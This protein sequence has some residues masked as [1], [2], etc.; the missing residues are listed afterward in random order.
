MKS[1]V[2]VFEITQPIGMFA[3]L[4][5]CALLAKACEEK[6]I[7]P[8]IVASSPLYLS[9]ARG[10]DWF[11]YFFGHKRIELTEHDIAALRKEGRILVIRD[12]NQINEFAR[13]LA[14]HEISNEFSKFSEAARLF[15]KYF[16]VNSHVL[17]SVAEF[18]E[19]NF[20]RCGQLGMHYRGTDHFHEYKF[21]DQQL[22]VD[23][24][25][26]HFPEYESIFIATDE[27]RFL[28][29]VRSHMPGKRIVT[30][31]P[32]PPKPHTID[33]GDNYRKGS[34][35][36]ADCL[37]LSRCH[38]LVKTP[39]ALSTWSKVLGPDLNLVLVGKPYSNPW[40]SSWSNLDGLGFFPES[41]LYRWDAASMTENRVIK[42]I[43]PPGDRR[44]RKLHPSVRRKQHYLGGAST[45]V[46]KLWLRM[47]R[48]GSKAVKRVCK[49]NCKP[50]T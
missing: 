11:S 6:G 27:K 49:P 19:R 44:P 7:E 21:I 12:R 30:F 3:T 14:T 32:E 36:L 35:A 42:I 45:T 28:D 37:L 40:K 46:A 17:A 41:L 24:A 47:V 5:H 31:M 4:S 1:E 2:Q 8:Y 34:H 18:I 13:G 20:D 9:P 50:T 39:S 26:E 16:R 43:A 15:G 25:T 38:A 29:L 33:Q 22:M 23:A 10:N 48:L